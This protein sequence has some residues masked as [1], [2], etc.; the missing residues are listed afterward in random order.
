M[1]PGARLI[2]VGRQGAGKGTQCVRLSRHYVVPHI[3]TG[4]MLRAAVKAG[5]PL[6]VEAGTPEARRLAMSAT[7]FHWG[8]HPW[9]VYALM[10]LALAFFTYNK[11]LPLTIRSCF[12]PL[13][14]DRVWGWSGHIIDTLA[15]L[16]TLFGL[17]TSL[18]FGAMQAASGLNLL[19]GIDPGVTTQI[20]IIVGVTSFA[21]LSVIR[22]IDGGI[23]LLSNINIILAIILLLFVLIAGPTLAILIGMPVNALHYLGDLV[24]LAL[25]DRSQFGQVRPHRGDVVAAGVRC[26][27]GLC[28]RL[29]R[30]AAS[31][32]LA[33][34]PDPSTVGGAARHADPDLQ[35]RGLL[36]HR[37]RGC[38]CPKKR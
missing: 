11:G 23:K 25:G 22:G 37:V 12:Y 28:G 20:G 27:D 26:R 19:F 13:L 15:V 31:A 3:S 35:C 38:H 32:R 6:G 4:D 2:I 30:R 14:G 34:S 24:P 1:I 17:A 36:L 16:A 33:A 21:T 18:G 10:G 29:G 5:T 7:I 8:F 9:A